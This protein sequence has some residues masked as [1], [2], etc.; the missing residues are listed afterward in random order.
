MEEHRAEVG[1]ERLGLAFDL[2]GCSAFMMKDYDAA[3]KYFTLAIEQNPQ[4]VDFHIN[5]GAAQRSAGQ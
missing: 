3:I 2:A 5:K 1:K 4:V